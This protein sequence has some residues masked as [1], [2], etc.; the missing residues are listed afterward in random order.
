L[1]DAKKLKQEA[2]T[3]RH[4]FHQ[5]HFKILLFLLVVAV[6]VDLIQ[7]YFIRS[8]VF[9]AGLSLAFFVGIYFLIQQRI[10]SLKELLGTLLYTG[11]VLLVP[12]SLKH[13]LS[14][15]VILLIIQFGIIVW[16]NLLLFSWIDK[17][18]DEKDRHHSF[19]T[20]FGFTVTK[21][22]LL[23][24]F[25]LLAV[26]AIVQLVLSPINT[27]A[28]WILSLM[29]MFLLLIFLK[30]DFFEAEDRY[31]LLG[32]AVFLLPVIYLLIK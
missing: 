27:L 6:F 2:S 9:V 16:I 14:S 17:P 15:S 5:R 7:I 32:D 1:L 23:S 26:L 11:G 30:K 8:I 21:K 10:G 12:L 19:A 31:R 24:L 20:T 22:I 28:V 4:R 25:S 13:Q 18:K 29:A 3:Q